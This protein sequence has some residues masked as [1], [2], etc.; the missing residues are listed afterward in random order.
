MSNLIKCDLDD[1]TVKWSEH[2]LQVAVIQRLR[3]LN[4]LYAAD[5]NGLRT[6]K[7]QGAMAKQAGMMAGEPDI[8]IYLNGGRIIFIEMK[9]IRGSIS[10]IQRQR[11]KALAE[12]GHFVYII[13]EP[14]PLKAQDVAES[15]VIYH[16]CE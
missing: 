6:S 1:S 7:R 3:K 16:E 14:T 4:V 8:R 12:L 10:A 13:K 15:I 11:H 2:E 9:T 5:Q